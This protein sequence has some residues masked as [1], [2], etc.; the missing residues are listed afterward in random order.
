MCT[1]QSYVG[2]L[3]ETVCAS[4]STPLHT[5]PHY[6]SPAV[7]VCCPIDSLRRCK[8]LWHELHILAEWDRRVR[9]HILAS[10]EHILQIL[11]FSDSALEFRDWT[12]FQRR[13]ACLLY[14]GLATSGRGSRAQSGSPQRHLAD[15]DH[16]P[17]PRESFLYLELLSKSRL[18]SRRIGLGATVLPLPPPTSRPNQE[19]E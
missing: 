4:N 8:H 1:I 17:I 18:K 5:R 9:W 14:H 12:S 6:P 10:V 3:C 19:V 15:C 13:P 16:C 2:A 7:D 11:R